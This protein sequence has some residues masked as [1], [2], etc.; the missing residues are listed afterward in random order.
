MSHTGFNSLVNPC[1]VLIKRQL[2]NFEEIRN[3]GA[4]V[5][6]VEKYEKLMG[7]LNLK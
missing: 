5:E 2:P 7:P 1:I 3:Y 4:D 6:E